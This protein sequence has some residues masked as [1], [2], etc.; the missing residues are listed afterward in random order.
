MFMGIIIDTANLKLWTDFN[1][2]DIITFLL[3]NMLWDKPNLMFGDLWPLPD[4][5]RRLANFDPLPA[6][7][8]MLPLRDRPK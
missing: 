8:E 6:N 1:Q 7:D 3:L 4:Q 2:T 5:N